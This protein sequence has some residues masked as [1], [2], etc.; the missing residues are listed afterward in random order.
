MDIYS[1]AAIQIIKEQQAVI[2]PIAVDQAKRVPGL[3]V[4]TMG[5]VKIIGDGK[6]TIAKLV[7]QYEKFFGE[8]SVQVCKD[9]IKEVKPPIPNDELPE[10][11]K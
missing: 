11:L 9:A 2:G 5:D 4:D 8:A 1:L 7:G 3:S 10:I 6:E